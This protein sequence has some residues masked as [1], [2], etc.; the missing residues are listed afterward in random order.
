[1]LTPLPKEDYVP[2]PFISEAT[3]PYYN[4]EE[5]WNAY[6]RIAT[7]VLGMNLF[8]YQ[9]EIFRTVAYEQFTCVAS[10]RQMGK[11][12]A[13]AGLALT[14]ALSIP[15]QTVIIISTG[16]RNVKELLTKREFSIKKIFKNM[17]RNAS[18]KS[19]INIIGNY[20]S[21]DWG[22][23]KV[24]WSIDHENAEEI[25]FKNGS[26]IVVVPASPDTIAG[27][28]AD[29]VLADEIAKMPDW[30]EMF[31]AFFPFISRTGG[32]VVLFSSVK[33]ENHFWDIMNDVKSEENPYGWAVLKYPITI[34][35]PPNLEHIKHLMTHAAY[36]EEMM[37]IPQSAAHS[38]F[39]YELV[40]QCAKGSQAAW[41]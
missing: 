10:A 12:V 24:D 8:D 17:Q 34:N 36:M 23:A 15:N 33:G 41:I 27:F 9:A 18:P 25:E 37:L 39:P 4:S 3:D 28:S 19:L 16:E 13:I 2:K 32:K 11:S 5:S 14:H 35:P 26:R 29:L 7:Q 30:A 6:V 20:S 1:M 40:D 21:D 38:H 22:Q 31:A